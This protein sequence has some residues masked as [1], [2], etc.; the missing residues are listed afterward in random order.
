M[1]LLLQFQN[2]I[3]LGCYINSA[4]EDQIYECEDDCTNT[5]T[6]TLKFCDV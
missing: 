1:N 2:T 5:N 3:C 4:D 6:H